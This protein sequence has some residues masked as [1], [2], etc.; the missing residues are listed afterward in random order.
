MHAYRYTCIYIAHYVIVL[1]DYYLA[2][3]QNYGN[4]K[5]NIFHAW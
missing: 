1:F 3:G 4:F 5:I 2:M